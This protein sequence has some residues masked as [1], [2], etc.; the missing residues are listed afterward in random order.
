[1]SNPCR[2]HN[3][4]IFSNLDLH[5]SVKNIK[6]KADVLRLSNMPMQCAK[7]CRGHIQAS[8]IADEKGNFECWRL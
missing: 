4:T 2:H 8:Q 6:I 7:Q 5:L 1:M 3:H